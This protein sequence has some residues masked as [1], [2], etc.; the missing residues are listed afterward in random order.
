MIILNLFNVRAFFL[1]YLDLLYCDT[2]SIFTI[3]ILAANLWDTTQ[4]SSESKVNCLI[5]PVLN[6]IGKNY[7]YSPKISILNIS[8]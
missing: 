4:V 6:I 8:A 3:G 1:I 2:D 5:R 7:L